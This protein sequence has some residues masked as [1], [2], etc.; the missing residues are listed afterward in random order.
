M[1]LDVAAPHDAL[2]WL[3]RPRQTPLIGEFAAKSNVR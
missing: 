1:R 2:G 3:R